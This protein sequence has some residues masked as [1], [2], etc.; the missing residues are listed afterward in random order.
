MRRD[1][2][3]VQRGAVPGGHSGVPGDQACHGA[4]ADP[5]AAAGGEDRVVAPEGTF[6]RMPGVED[7]TDEG[8]DEC[9]TTENDGDDAGRA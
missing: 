9:E 6:D 1:V 2:L 3:A 8:R 7:V 5:G 4:A